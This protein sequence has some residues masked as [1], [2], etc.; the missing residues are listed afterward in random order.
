V[1]AQYP[2]YILIPGGKAIRVENEVQHKRISP[3]DFQ[4]FQDALAADPTHGR[5]MFIENAGADAERERCAILAETFPKAGKVGLLIAAAIRGQIDEI[6]P[7]LLRNP[8]SSPVKDGDFT[9]PGS[10][11]DTFLRPDVTVN[12]AVEEEAAR[13]EGFTVVVSPPVDASKPDGTKPGP[14]DAVKG[15]PKLLRDP[16]TEDKPDAAHTE[17]RDGK[18]ARP[19]VSVA[20][21]AEEAA[22][23]AAGH[24]VFVK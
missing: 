16:R 23:R 5:A 7:K 9:V 12:D 3:D 2:R 21:P 24:T 1:Q 18:Y 13:A 14:K 8:E 17:I 19:D 22:A 20:N 6:F 4:A 10:K 15:F 11:P